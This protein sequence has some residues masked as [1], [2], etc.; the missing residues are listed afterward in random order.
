MHWEPQEN[1]PMV[2][3][4]WHACTDVEAMLAFVG[5]TVSER[6]LRLFASAC[7]RRLWPLLRESGRRA[8]D[9]QEAFLDGETDRAAWLAAWDVTWREDVEGGVAGVAQPRI[10]AAAAVMHTV[11]PNGEVAGWY[12]ANRMEWATYAAQNAALA[13][14]EAAGENPGYPP[15][16]K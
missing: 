6:K 5:D 12:T 13:A 10:D 3:S 8:L 11:R 15:K 9:V 16:G 4:K 7:C 1:E 2:E 14:V